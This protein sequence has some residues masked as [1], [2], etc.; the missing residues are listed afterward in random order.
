MT[1]STGEW[2]AFGSLAVAGLVASG[3]GVGHAIK[4]SYRF[5]RTDQEQDEIR[6]RLD[7]VESRADVADAHKTTLELV[8]QAMTALQEQVKEMR[9]DIKHLLTGRP[10]S[11]RN[12][13]SD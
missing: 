9:D 12:P 3:M 10:S 13:E 1:W 11:R 6:K 2:I 4:V 5:G 7:K 8:Q